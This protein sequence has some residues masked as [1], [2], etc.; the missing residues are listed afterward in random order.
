MSYIVSDKNDIDLASRARCSRGEFGI[1]PLVVE[2]GADTN[3]AFLVSGL[4]DELIVLVA[5]ALDGSENV[6]GI[7]HW[8]DRF[9]GKVRLQF[10]AANVLGNGVV[11]MQRGRGVS[12]RG[13]SWAVS[14]RR[15]SVRYGAG[16]E[17]FQPPA[18]E[19]SCPADNNVP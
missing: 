17:A 18:I 11:D 12:P 4:V 5:P 3:G 19:A 15:V 16:C 9:A 8:R 7:V 10:K 6:Q 1:K 2:G 13:G 14:V